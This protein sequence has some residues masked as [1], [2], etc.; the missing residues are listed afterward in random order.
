MKRSLNLFYTLLFLLVSNSCNENIS[1]VRVIEPTQI[2]STVSASDVPSGVLDLANISLANAK[3]RTQFGKFDLDTEKIKFLTKTDSSRSYTFRSTKSTSIDFINVVVSEANDNLNT[4]IIHYQPDLDWLKFSNNDYRSF[5]GIA[6]VYDLNSNIFSTA[7]YVNG[8]A[9]EL[10]DSGDIDR[11]RTCIT[12]IT[13]TEEEFCSCSNHQDDHTDGS[14][15][16]DERF[17]TVVETHCFGETTSGGGGGSG[18][19]GDGSGDG[20]GGP[21]GGSG[22]TPDENGGST[23][24]IYPGDG[25]EDPIH[26][27]LGLTPIESDWLKSNPTVDSQIKNFLVENGST[28][29]SQS[30]AYDL[31]ISIMYGDNLE[32]SAAYMTLA[33][34]DVNQIDGPYNSLYFGA[35]NQYTS[36]DFS[37]PD[38]Q[39]IWMQHFTTQCA[40]LKL[41]NPDWPDYKIYWEASKEMIH[42]ALDVAGLVPVVGELFDATNGVLYT[43]EGD[44]VN[45]TLS[46]ASTIPIAGWFSTGAKF[47][48]KTV[49][50]A[51]TSKTTLKWTLKT[52]DIVLFGNRNQLARVLGTKGTGQHAHHIIPWETGSH[53][54]VQK[55]AKSSNEFHMNGALNGIPLSSTSHLTGHNIYNAKVTEVLDNIE[56][57]SPDEAYTELSNFISYLSNLIKNN[58]NKNLGEI[59]GMINY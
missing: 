46:F 25:E 40:I 20:G 2:I 9:T 55:A 53:P 59:A 12:V 36:V 45:A 1:E 22:S 58:P 52:D 57:F 26:S 10:I 48:F 32:Q 15:V 6:S 18:D 31:I 30:F 13:T 5:T 39:E 11:G 51:N 23:G 38:L 34:I 4:L 56:A 24:V 14:C 8:K 41:V 44:G 7:H 43:I 19:G 54:L 35:I 50:V 16:C 21:S 28:I 49:D 27:Q 42:P 47:A 3:T 37:N 29:D 33:A 17:E